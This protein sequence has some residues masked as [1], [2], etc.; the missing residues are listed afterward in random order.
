MSD[1]IVSFETSLALQPSAESYLNLIQL[2]FFTGRKID[3]VTRALHAQTAFP[4]DPRIAAELARALER[5]GDADG[6]TQ[7]LRDSTGAHFPQP[8]PGPCLHMAPPTSS[9]AAAKSPEAITLYRQALAAYPHDPRLHSAL[10]FTLHFLPCT[11]PAQIAAEHAD[12]NRH[13]API[14]LNLSY[15]NE[16]AIQNVGRPLR[17]GYVSPDFRN[18]GVGRFIAPLLEHHTKADFQVFAYSDVHTSDALTHRICNAVSAY[19]STFNL[20]VAELAS[21][22]RTDQIEILIDLTMHMPSNRLLAF[23]RKPAPV[24]NHLLQR[25][26]LYHWPPTNRLPHYR[27]IPRS[28]R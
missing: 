5:T 13:D 1:A 24:Q 14:A 17:I 8:P 16:P 3:A 26:L 23:A 11:T 27:S 28:A 21:L 10:L 2:F 7:N 12:W 20:R 25:I 6:R 15:N 18:H 9:S 22:I 19:R 4:N